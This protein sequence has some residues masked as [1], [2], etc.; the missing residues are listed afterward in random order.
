VSARSRA[1]SRQ[2]DEPGYDFDSNVR[3]PPQSQTLLSLPL[4]CPA[5][6]TEDE[7][8]GHNII[9]LDACFLATLNS[10][11]DCDVRPGASTLGSCHQARGASPLLQVLA[12][13]RRW[14]AGGLPPLRSRKKD[15]CCSFRPLRPVSGFGRRRPKLRYYRI[16]DPHPAAWHA[17]I[18]RSPGTLVLGGVL[19]F[20]SSSHSITE[21]CLFGEPCPGRHS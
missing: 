6:L 20:A 3:D 5:V 21:D 19:S 9:T 8:Q 13:R 1:V 4:R 14:V 12:G 2:T 15:P 7:M 18:E 17:G 16:C 11:G 10:F